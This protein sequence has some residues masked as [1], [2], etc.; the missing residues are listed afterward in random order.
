MDLVIA[1]GLL[2]AHRALVET[3]LDCR[4]TIPRLCVL[5]L[6]LDRPRIEPRD[7]QALVGEFDGMGQGERLRGLRRREGAYGQLRRLHKL[8]LMSHCEGTGFYTLEARARAVLERVLALER[9][10]EGEPGALEDP[11]VGYSVH[12]QEFPGMPSNREL[13]T[14]PSGL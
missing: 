9:R 13:L 12:V 11:D 10:S 5:L 14:L 3:S 6:A 7:I 4:V 1:F 2:W 8:G